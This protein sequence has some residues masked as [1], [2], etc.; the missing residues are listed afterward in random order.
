MADTKGKARQRPARVPDPTRTRPVPGASRNGATPQDD[1]APVDIFDVWSRTGSKYRIR[2]IILLLVNLLLFA[3][4][5][6]F[7]FWLRTGTALAPATG[8]YWA[9]FAEIFNPS[10]ETEVT[11]GSLATS[12]ISV[13]EVPM[14][15][16]ILGLLLAALVSIPILVSILYRFPACLPFLGVVAFLAMMPWLAITLT[17]SCVLA[18]V[19]PFR[20]QFR[21]ASALLGLLL[22]MVYFYGASRSVATPVDPLGSPAD[23]IKFIAPWILAAVASCALTGF[24]LMIAHMVN[25]RPGAIA[26]L[27]ALMFAIPVALFEF[28]VGRDELHYRLLEHAYGPGAACFADQDVTDEFERAVR[29]DWLSR[30][31]PKPP[32]QV[33]ED[34]I[35]LAWRVHLATGP[36]NIEIA[37]DRTAAAQRADWFLGHYPDSR[38]AVNALY[39]KGMALDLRVD[40]TAFRYDRMLRFFGKHGA[41]FPSESS[42]RCWMM[43]VTNGPGSPMAAVAMLR[44]A[45]LDARAGEIA[46]ATAWLNRLIDDFDR[47]HAT[48]QRETPNNILTRKPVAATLAVPLNETLLEAHHLL[49]LLRNNRDPLYGFHPVMEMLR[50]YPKTPHYCEN[51]R[52]LLDR[53]PTAQIADN[54]ELEIALA[55]PDIQEKIALLEACV[56]RYPQGDALPE[57]LYRLGDALCEADRP[58]EA[59]QYYERVLHDYPDSIWRHQ[60]EGRLRVL[61]LPPA[62]ATAS[63]GT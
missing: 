63:D 19:R 57:I 27:L 11:L 10:R 37:D 55:T 21:F 4:L 46:Q 59:R 1:A 9:T 58:V 45:T 61:V 50:L 47:N 5:G 31:D 2:S 22:V 26:P 25:H 60:A 36:H 62:S 49:L 43:V 53:Y 30:P 23:R 15:I 34:Q 24:V 39:V 28:R 48:L 51:L 3:G 33:V 52:G 35:D 54:I 17:G 44:L 14:Q 18:S 56:E 20:F 38:Y 12:P 40:E 42:R 13:E 32:R 16:V 29:A 41:A 7:A 8:D 6:C